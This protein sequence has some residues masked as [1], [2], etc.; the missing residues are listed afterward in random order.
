MPLAALAVPAI[1]GAASSAAGAGIMAATGAGK[2]DKTSSFTDPNYFNRRKS[3]YDPNAFELGGKA[4]FADAE[5]Q[6]FQGMGDWAQTRDPAQFNQATIAQ[7]RDAQT[8]ALGMYQDA[9][10]GRGPSA[11]QS[12]LRM[13]LDQAVRDQA[14]MAAS[15]RGGALARSSLGLAG[16]N[17]AATLQGQAVGQS[18]MLRAQEQQA[19]MAGYAGM[20]NA[21]RG[22]DQ[23][24]MMAQAQMEADQRARNDA[25]QQWAESA[26]NSVRGQQL[27]AAMQR[28]QTL[29]NAYQTTQ[30]IN[31]GIEQVNANRDMQYLQ[32]G[33]GGVQGAMQGAFTGGKK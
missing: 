24:Q 31:A 14:G 28:Q 12:Q 13:G 23:Q 27:A 22:V 8:G 16:A 32:A 6:R 26:A 19:G 30:A 4:G 10:M 1:V 15:A 25:Y 21:L 33:I 18:A 11:A 2:S 20:A 29:Q 9:A 5:A 7:A 3:G 17:N